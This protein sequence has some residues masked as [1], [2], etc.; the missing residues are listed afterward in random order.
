MIASPRS[1][2]IGLKPFSANQSIQNEEQGKLIPEVAGKA[3]I[4][5]SK[6][7]KVGKSLWMTKAHQ[8][9]DLSIFFWT[10]RRSHERTV[11]L[12]RTSSVLFIGLMA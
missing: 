1:W 9:R 7:P 5:G 11:S 10:T 3:K 8:F 4:K 6:F 2:K 12:K